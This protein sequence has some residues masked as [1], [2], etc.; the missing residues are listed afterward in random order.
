MVLT[1]DD[2]SPAR[3]QMIQTQL[4]SEVARCHAMV[5]I[6]DNDLSSIRSDAAM[7]DEE[8]LH[9]PLDVYDDYLGML[10]E[11]ERED[12]GYYTFLYTYLL[13]YLEH[14]RGGIRIADDLLAG[15]NPVGEK[16]TIR[17]LKVR[18]ILEGCLE[19]CQMLTDVGE[20]SD[21]PYQNAGEFIQ[22]NLEEISIM[23]RI[24]SCREIDLDEM[25]FHLQWADTLDPQPFR[26]LFL[27]DMDPSDLAVYTEFDLAWADRVRA[28]IGRCIA[29]TEL[30]A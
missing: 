26:D 15:R 6:A 20:D 10:K 4:I 22:C 17:L 2:I 16:E 23:L 27:I 8:P 11:K 3:R 9:L 18:T 7:L 28:I 25:A 5:R 29:D 1:R 12:E 30:G 13:G 19:R 14:I 24:G 21:V